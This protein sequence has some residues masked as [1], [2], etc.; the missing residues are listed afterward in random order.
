MNL[1]KLLAAGAAIG[2]ILVSYRDERGEWIVPGRGLLSTPD[3]SDGGAEPT[4]GYDGMDDDT[5]TDWI[6]EADLDRSTLLNMLRYE[7]AGRGRQ[8]ILAAL[9]DQL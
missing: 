1:F 4:L 6:A 5:L 9:V 3:R 7:A 8:P 2:V